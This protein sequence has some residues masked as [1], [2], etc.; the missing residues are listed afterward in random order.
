MTALLQGSYES[1]HADLDVNQVFGFCF[2]RL[3]S[4]LIKIEGFGEF[5][6]AVAVE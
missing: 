6:S 5:M 1:I 2:K 3:Q 4:I